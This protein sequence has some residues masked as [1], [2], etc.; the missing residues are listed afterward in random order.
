[1]RRPDGVRESRLV[2]GATRASFGDEGVGFVEE[3]GGLL[4]GVRHEGVGARAGITGSIGPVEAVDDARE[5]RGPVVEEIGHPAPE[6]PP[7]IGGEQQTQREADG[8][9]DEGAEHGGTENASA[10][11]HGT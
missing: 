7:L 3:L 6:L 9:A 8:S 4:A 10:L 1:M 5:V 11:T 2:A